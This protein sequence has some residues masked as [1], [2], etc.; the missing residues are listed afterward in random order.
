MG[1]IVGVD[2]M[3]RCPICLGVVAIMLVSA[4]V[5]AEGGAGTIL[6]MQGRTVLQCALDPVVLLPNGKIVRLPSL[7]SDASAVA[8]GETDLLVYGLASGTIHVYRK[9]PAEWFT[10]PECWLYEPA[11]SAFLPCA[12]RL[13]SPGPTSA[14]EFLDQPGTL[15]YFDS[16]A[17]LVLSPGG[18]GIGDRDRDGLPDIRDSCPTIAN[19]DQAD[20]DADTV[21]DACDNCTQIANPDQLD[22][23]GD[24]IGNRCDCDFNQDNFC[25]GP[26]FTLFIGCFNAP[27]GDDPTCEAADMNGDGFVGGP[28]FTLFIGGFNGPPGPFGVAP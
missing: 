21:G 14:A 7:M 20:G 1:T 15:L 2:R 26:D 10:G 17:A 5:S 22:S 24:G 27:T 18:M 13:T 3:S 23:D 16:E 11:R 6:A 9:V 25:G 19:V 28:D 8:A 12:E 4:A